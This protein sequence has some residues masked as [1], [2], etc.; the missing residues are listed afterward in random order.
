[1]SDGAA[2]SPSPE[3]EAPPAPPARSAGWW[4]RENIRQIVSAM[5]I[6]LLVRH[7][8]VEIFKIP[9]GSMAETLYGN[10][11]DVECPRCGWAFPLGV[12]EGEEGLIAQRSVRCA[13]CDLLLP[14]GA[15]RLDLRCGR[16]ARGF[17]LENAPGEETD[18]A[19][20]PACGLDGEAV[21]RGAEPRADAHETLKE[22]W[23]LRFPERGGHKIIANK[24]IYALREPRRWEVVVFRFHKDGKWFNYIKRLVGLPGDRDLSIRH[25]DVFLEGKLL[26]KP[27]DVQ[28][29]V[30]IGVYDS[31]SENEW[32]P[33]WRPEGSAERRAGGSWTLDAS[34]GGTARLVLDRPIGSDLGYN[35]LRGG[36][37]G[38]GGGHPVGDL[39]LRLD[40]SVGAGAAL[41]GAIEEDGAA[42][43][44][45]LPTKGDGRIEEIR[46]GAVT[47]SWPARGGLP[48]GRAAEVR[49]EN[50]DGR[51][52]L[53]VDGEVRAAVDLAEPF[54]PGEARG[55]GISV[56]AEDGAA[57]LS[58]VRID[59]DVFYLGEG[60]GAF[61]IAPGELFFLGDNSSNSH[62]SRK[63]YDPRHQQVHSVRRDRILGR[64]SFSILYLD[65]DWPWRIPWSRIDVSGVR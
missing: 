5:V 44:F 63:W 7:Y 33:A 65:F 9:T 54:P 35:L 16:C 17:T 53:S 62:D 40:A 13:S 39:R 45:R 2:P 56:W 1:M 41:C 27:W 20:C 12:P 46:D 51:L 49:L 3:A 58:R 22:R 15:R 18:R 42:Y 11:L 55:A 52:R 34:G 31:R 10:H 60:A 64:A 36:G 48:A 28:D 26:A 19:A 43:R 59:R 8:A 25:G 24:W 21:A 47:R 23:V 61:D 14:L 38:S 4:I 37:F 50:A 32:K 57:E 29:A 6:V 30:W